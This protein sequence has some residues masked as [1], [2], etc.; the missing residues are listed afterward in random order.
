MVDLEAGRQRAQV[1]TAASGVLMRKVTRA[2]VSPCCPS[3]SLRRL[4]C[5]FQ[6]HVSRR[7]IP[8]A[9]K[10]PPKT[11]MQPTGVLARRQT[12]MPYF[13]TC[14]SPHDTRVPIH[15]YAA[16]LAQNA[17]EMQG[18]HHRV[19]CLWCLLTHVRSKKGGILLNPAET[20]CTMSTGSRNLGRASSR[21]RSAARGASTRH[22]SSGGCTRG[23]H[24]AHRWG[25]QRRRREKNE[26]QH[27]PAGH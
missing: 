26:R 4:P 17:W 22:S 23:H 2:C 1:Y 3:N 6:R 8:A 16:T 14:A 25:H 27:F 20:W 21:H 24:E 9:R 11:C 5:N 19:V 18:R 13:R 15:K 10:I 12:P 7:N